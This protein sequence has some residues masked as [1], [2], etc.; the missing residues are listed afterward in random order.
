MKKILIITI[1]FF[2][3]HIVSAQEKTN[4]TDN[5]IYNVAGIEVKPEFPGGIDKFYT[6]IAENYKTPKVE[7][8]S[9]KVFVT[10]I[11]E[12]DGSITGIKVLRDIGYDTGKEAIRVLALSPKWMPGQQNGK[13]VRCTYALPINIV[14]R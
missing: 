4:V 14:A 9:G 5:N 1:A 10:F 7:K 8:L 12:K 13:T 2:F 11:I 6:F 3:S